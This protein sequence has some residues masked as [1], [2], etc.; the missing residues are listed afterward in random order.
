MLGTLDCGISTI[1]ERFTRTMTGWAG[2]PTPS[3]RCTKKPKPAPTRRNGSAA[4]PNWPWNNVC[5]PSAV[6]TGNVSSPGQAVPPGGAAHQRT[7]RL[8]GRN[9]SPTGQQRRRAQLAS[10]GGQPQGQRRNPLTAGTET[11]MTLASVF[12]TWRAQG[13]NPLSA[14]RQL[15]ISPQF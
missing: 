3:T 5:W 8:R 15:L 10:S 14:C 6:P 7:L 12:G 2:G 11:K 4:G 13:L 9:G 1:C